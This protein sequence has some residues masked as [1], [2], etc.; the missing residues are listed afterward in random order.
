MSDAL[1]QTMTAIEI[2]TPGGPEVLRPVPRPRPEPAAE[3]V[4][5]NIYGI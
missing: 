1:P 4:L 3:E 5:I 2:S